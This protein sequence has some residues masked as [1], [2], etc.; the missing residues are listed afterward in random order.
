MVETSELIEV[1]TGHLTSDPLAVVLVLF[2][3]V[4]VAW[5][6]LVG[7]YLTLRGIGAWF[8]GSPGQGPPRQAE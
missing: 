4:L 2:G 1:L 8:S 6:S 5:P 3:A 7:G